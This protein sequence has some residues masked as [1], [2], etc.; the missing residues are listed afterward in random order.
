MTPLIVVATLVL[1]GIFAA[2]AYLELSSGG[3]GRLG[4]GRQ[5]AAPE[6]RPAVPD[7]TVWRYT[8]IVC[9]SRVWV[10]VPRFTLV[11][12]LTV[13]P[14]VGSASVTEVA[15]KQRD[16]VRARIDAPGF[17][18]LGPLEQDIDVTV[19]G[20]SSP[21]VFDLK[22]A[23]TGVS[24]V[25]LHLT[26]GGNPVGIATLAIEVVDHEVAMRTGSPIPSSVALVHDVAPPDYL[27]YVSYDGGGGRS[28]L[29]FMLIDLAQGQL[30]VRFAPLRITSDPRTWAAGV[31]DQLSEM[32]E[33]SAAGAEGSAFDRRVKEVGQKMWNELIPPDLKQLYRERPFRGSSL[34]VLSDE[35][36]LPWELVWPYDAS[37]AD[38]SE[39][40]A[41]WCCTT[42]FARWLTRDET[43]S[44]NASPP[45][46]LQVGAMAILAPANT[47]LDGAAD[48][49]D[50]LESF[51][52]QAHVLDVS[53][54]ETTRP[55]VTHLLEAGKYDLLHVASHGEFVPASP[56]GPSV[57][58]L[59]DGGVFG[60]DAIV[61]R[62]EY[63]LRK[64]R[65]GFI[66]NA[67]H[68]G[69]ADQGITRIAGWANRLVSGGAGLFLA[70]MWTVSD[71]AAL[72]FSK[73]LYGALRSGVPVGEAVLKAR[74]SARATGTGDL[75]YLAYS[76]YAHPNAR[77]RFGTDGEP[78]AS[79]EASS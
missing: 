74:E 43:G 67:C 35:P 19:E 30:G 62:A 77:V 55:A 34:V 12:R 1:L 16:P 32:V 71:A 51:C 56:E 52:E 57:I 49:R 44:G 59:A 22:P 10:G 37:G 69:K 25:T 33:A 7:G 72:A 31:H 9:P 40:P 17:D 64:R 78:G 65:P 60:P 70:P 48:E 38:F 61:G 20:D 53:P 18:V 58:R 41:P 3:R 6:H 75:T 36:H 8:D 45:G 11:L 21:V 68:A 79:L 66:L 46:L 26:Q 50:Y 4:W 14:R 42:R 39:D 15:I 28:E 63:Q 5:G 54:E 29:R 47:G 27:L 76:L 23:R 24:T 73:A 2:Y 13:A